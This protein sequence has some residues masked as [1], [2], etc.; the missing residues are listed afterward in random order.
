M[1]WTHGKDE[2]DKFINYLNNIH[3][4]IKFTSEVSDTSV[5]FLDTT[6]KIDTDNIIYT[7]LYEKPIDTHLYLHYESAHHSPC[8]EKGPHGQFLRIRRICGK[9]Q[10]FIESGIK[11]IEH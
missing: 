9:N 6:V 2:L 3:P 11:M 8:H 10:D 7:T 4:Q 5:N 1:I